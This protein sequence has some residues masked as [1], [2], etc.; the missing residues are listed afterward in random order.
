MGTNGMQAR[1]IN[2]IASYTA[3]F[4]HLFRRSISVDNM[5][6]LFLKFADE[7]FRFSRVTDGPVE[8]VLLPSLRF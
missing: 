7:G 3:D 1:G 2:A 8:F 4:C 5:K 6:P